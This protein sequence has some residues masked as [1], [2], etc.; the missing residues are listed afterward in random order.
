[1]EVDTQG[2]NRL[3]NFRWHDD[4]RHRL[5]KSH[6]RCCSFLQ[7]TP[8][9]KLEWKAKIQRKTEFD[10]SLVFQRKINTYGV[11]KHNV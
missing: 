4:T 7:N 5:N 10:Y 8:L 1:M 3:S 2:C 9:R 6:N 11:L